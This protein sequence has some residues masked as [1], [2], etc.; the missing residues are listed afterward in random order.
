ME[1]SMNSINVIDKSKNLLND[2]INSIASISEANTAAT[3]EVTTTIQ[4]QAESNNLMNALAEGLNDKA[5]EL[6]K[7]INK[8]RF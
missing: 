7:L 6:I 8:F 3:E 2:S 5:N 4:T 1:V